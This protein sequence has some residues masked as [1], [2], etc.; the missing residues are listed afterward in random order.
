[1]NLQ[2][3][4]A[5]S[6]SS[7][8]RQHCTRRRK[9]ISW[10]RRAILR[11]VEVFDDFVDDGQGPFPPDFRAAMYATPGPNRILSGTVVCVLGYGLRRRL[12]DTT[13][14]KSWARRTIMQ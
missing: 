3:T 2:L 10:A 9:P 4:L 11:W 7:H 13:R 14:L 12:F 5:A 6:S 8:Q 1:M